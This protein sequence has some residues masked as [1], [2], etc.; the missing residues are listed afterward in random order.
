[1]DSEI[2]HLQGIYKLWA[3]AEKN[4]RQLLW[5]A[6]AAVVLGLGIYYYLWHQETAERT[7]AEE[8][9]QLRP[10][11]APSGPPTP[12]RAEEYLKLAGEHRGTQAAGRALLLGAGALFT[13]GKYAEARTEFE[14]FLHE[15]PDSPLRCEALY[16]SAACLDAEGNKAGEAAAAFKSV[17]DR[18]PLDPVVPRAK[19][20]LARVYEAQKQVEQA[21]QLYSEL[22]ETE[23]SSL[24]GMLAD[25]RLEDLKRTNP[26]L[27]VRAATNAMTV[28]PG[29]QPPLVVHPATPSAPVA[30]TNKP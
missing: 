23:R 6:L 12:I 17:V 7:A 27:G 22:S 2:A 28:V 3:W 8:L 26:S 13:N 1:M 30:K 16:G 29:A 10:T 11:P 14:R 20:A 9:A 5:A 4:K 19:L 24:V 25:M 21:Y 18:Y 15:Y